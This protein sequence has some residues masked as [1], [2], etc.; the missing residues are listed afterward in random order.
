MPSPVDDTGSPSIEA[1]NTVNALD[2][3]MTKPREGVNSK[4][5]HFTFTTLY[6]LLNTP[7]LSNLRPL[8]SLHDDRKPKGQKLC[9]KGVSSFFFLLRMERRTLEVAWTEINTC[10]KKVSFR[11]G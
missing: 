6:F 3:S 11:R 4:K 1:A 5:C 9:Q 8:S 7:Y 10:Q 2:R